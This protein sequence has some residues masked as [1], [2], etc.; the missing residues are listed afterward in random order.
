[1]ISGIFQ[2]LKGSSKA[3]NFEVISGLQHIF[4]KK[5]E[6]FEKSITCQGRYY[7]KKRPSLHLHKV[8]TPSTN[9]SA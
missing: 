5:A 1:M 2:P 9:V 7:D 3:R 6:C 4:E 8:L